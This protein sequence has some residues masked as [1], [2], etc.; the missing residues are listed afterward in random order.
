MIRA[1]MGFAVLPWL[2]LHGADAWSDDR[3]HIHELRPTP[4]REIFL[5]WPARHTQSP[6]AVRAIQ[7]AVEVANTLA[8][9]MQTDE[10]APPP[11]A[12]PRAAQR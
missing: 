5:Y 3:L 2:A 4:T 7:I 6:L 11:P 8:K 9:Q 1:G 12:E 10:P